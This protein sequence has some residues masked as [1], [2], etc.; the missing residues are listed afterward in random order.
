MFGSSIL[1]I[2][3]G[4]VF[5]FLLLSTFATAVNEIIFPSLTCEVESCCEELRRCRVT[6]KREAL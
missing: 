3:I 5:V 2:A 6:R 1:D 4:T